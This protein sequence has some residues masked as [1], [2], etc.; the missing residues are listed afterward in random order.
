MHNTHIY[1]SDI[2]IRFGHQQV[3]TDTARLMPR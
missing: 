2:A 1:F 3:L